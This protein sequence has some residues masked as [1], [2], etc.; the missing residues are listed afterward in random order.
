MYKKKKILTVV[1]V[2]NTVTVSKWRKYMNFSAQMP[3]GNFWEILT[4]NISG[5]SLNSE[6]LA[7]TFTVSAHEQW[8]HQNAKAGGVSRQVNGIKVHAEIGDNYSVNISEC[9]LNL[10]FNRSAVVIPLIKELVKAVIGFH[11]KKCMATNCIWSWSWLQQNCR[12]FWPTKI[13]IKS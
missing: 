4:A 10:T 3:L 2:K 13:S 1:I 12:G 9:Q 8:R 7:F 11:N 6:N 5:V